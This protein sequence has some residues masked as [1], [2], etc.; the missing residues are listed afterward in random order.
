MRRSSCGVTASPRLNSNRD[1]VA[2]RGAEDLGLHVEQQ[3]GVVEE[4]L[5]VGPRG[6]HV[7]R[8]GPGGLHADRHGAA[9]ALGDPEQRLP[10]V[11][12]RPQELAEVRDRG[13]RQVVAHLL[14]LLGRQILVARFER[15]QRRV[16]VLASDEAHDVGGDGVVAARE[17]QARDGRQRRGERDEVVA[18]QRPQEVG[19]L[20]THD[21]RVAAADVI[22]VEEDDEQPVLLARGLALL[23][24]GRQ[25]LAI[26]GRIVGAVVGLDELERLN[27]LRLAA[28]ADLEVVGGEIGDGTA[29]LVR[30]GDVD[31]DRV[32]AGSERRRGL[33]RVGLAGT[34]SRRRF[35]RA[36]QGQRGGDRD[37]QD[38]ADTCDSKPEHDGH[39]RSRAPGR[40]GGSSIIASAPDPAGRVTL[41]ERR[42]R[43]AD[44]P[45]AAAPRAA[46]ACRR[47]RS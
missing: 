17:R 13:H 18:R 3:P 36:R 43:A 32:D 1:V 38:Q 11:A 24:G 28:L 21:H 35:L 16:L 30:D 37:E 2:L 5:R 27:R 42:P 14:D 22:V 15:V 10:A 44:A 19:D 46:R 4:G 29:L 12:Q 23:I 33:R 7:R 9:H 8:E 39:L 40:T 6:A 31:D 20:L 45:S 41:D 47:T 25:D 34:G 26:G